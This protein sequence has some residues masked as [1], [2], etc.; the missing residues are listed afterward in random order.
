MADQYENWR[1]TV[2]ASKT[3]T[4]R[5]N[6]VAESAIETA[7]REGVFCT[8]EDL[9]QLDSIRLHVISGDAETGVTWWDEAEVKIP[10]FSAKAQARRFAIALKSVNESEKNAAELELLRKNPGERMKLARQMGQHAGPV[11]TKKNL[12]PEQRAKIVAEMDRVGLKGSARITASR[13][14]GLD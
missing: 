2:G 10:A 12:T 4:A 9:I 13:A 7:S 5:W 8:R 1:N 6:Q 3:L 11:T 14:A